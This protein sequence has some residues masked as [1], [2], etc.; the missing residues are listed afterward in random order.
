[1]VVLLSV[2]WSNAKD[3]ARVEVAMRA[4]IR[5]MQ[6]RT[7]SLDALDPYLYLNYA[8]AWQNP[9]AS[10]GQASMANLRQIRRD[11]DPRKI[12]T[13]NKPGGFKLSG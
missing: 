13:V 11:Y 10:Y 6:K 12:F 1:M 5:T 8:A 3:D 7:S 4:L 9:F 2:T